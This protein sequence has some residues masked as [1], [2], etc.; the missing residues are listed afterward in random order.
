LKLQR[1]VALKVLLSTVAADHDRLARFTREAQLLAALNH[2]NIAQIHG[3]EDAAGVTALI[4][5]FVE[6]ED[7]SSRIARGRVPTDEALAIVHRDLK[8]ANVKLRPDGTIKVLDFGLAK[9][10]DIGA[11]GSGSPDSSPTITAHAT[12]AGVI[13][14]TVAYMSPEQARGKERVRRTASG[15]RTCRTTPGA[16]KCTFN[17]TQPWAA[18]LRFPAPAGARRPGRETVVSSF[19]RRP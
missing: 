19:T 11:G 17:P 1:D 5:E 16:K 3:S 4:L 14:G 9:T 7:L 12:G 6:G 13:L 2:P 8:P 15:S 10:V 18:A